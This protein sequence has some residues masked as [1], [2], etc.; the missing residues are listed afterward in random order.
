[1]KGRCILM[2]DIK[3]SMRKLLSVILS[4]TLIFSVLPV[5]FLQKAEAV[6]T[7]RTDMR[8]PN[9]VDQYGTPCWNGSD[10]GLNYAKWTSS[11]D[12]LRV[13]YPR[14]IYLD[15]SET[16]EE[17][18]YYQTMTWHWGDST[19]YRIIANGYLWGEKGNKNWS[20]G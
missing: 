11:P 6:A 17:A 13:D 1:M 8:H 18:G 12:Y 14:H 15:I 20:S 7:L 16:L 3:T 5:A 4:I 19:D 9:G 10:G 2:N